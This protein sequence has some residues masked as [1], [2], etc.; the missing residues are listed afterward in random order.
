M[1]SEFRRVYEGK[2]WTLSCG[3][4]SGIEKTAIIAFQQLLQYYV[5]YALEV[6]KV[7]NPSGHAALI[8][9]EQSHP[10]I[11]GLIRSGKLA[12]PAGPEGYSVALMAS[13]D[14][15]DSRW[16]VV[17][18]GDSRGVLY[19]VHE[20]SARLFQGGSL[21]DGF[22]GPERRTHLEKF[23]E[24]HAAEAPAIAN[25]GIWTWG[26]TIA[27]FVAFLDRMA[28]LK[29]NMLTI[30]NDELPLNIAEVIEAA[31]ARGIRI[32]LGFHWGWGHTG[33][34]DLARE[35]DRAAIREKVLDNYRR[36]YAH[37]DHDGIYFQTLTEHKVLENAGRSTA[38]WAC[39]LV[40]DTARALFEEF[41]DLRI[42]FGLHATSV[43][44]NYRDL[45]S[46]DPRVTIVW[47]DCFGQVPYTYYPS[48]QVEVT[49]DYEQML[50]Y[51]RRIATFRPGAEF[52]LVPKGWTCIRWQRD[53]ENHGPFLLGERSS[54]EARER[55]AMRQNDWDRIN[56]HWFE[57]YP[58]AA[59]FYRE[60][61]KV[62]RNLTA[63]A[64]VEDGLFEEQI[65][66]S[67]ALFGEMAWN[68]ERPDAEILARAL[69]PYYSRW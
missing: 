36:H 13:P 2:R 8:G 61:L 11:A 28:R 27:R 67:V 23:P 3:E 26:Y 66:P 10:R 57:H 32:I 4:F 9:T 20:L 17:A 37:L 51:S 45:E 12:A 58:L 59:R 35:E 1:Q 44:E 65:A 39:E 41:P 31:H 53:F 56:A 7:A 43:G 47:E 34:I 24:F 50:D 49:G 52:A 40:N 48:Q 63:T 21:L 18:G 6:G 19:G 29:L 25:R 16:L 5:P 38:W 15:A 69:R 60:M 30:W 33:S 14:D 64:L 68:P 42:Q 54:L 62:N 55:L 22:A 46:L